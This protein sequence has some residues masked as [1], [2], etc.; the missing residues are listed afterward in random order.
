VK[1]PY[2]IP[3]FNGKPG[4]DPKNHI[5]T[6]H[7]WF[8]SNS[9]MDESIRFRLFQRTLIDISTKWYV[10]LPQHSFKNFNTLVMAFL[11]HF[12]LPNQYETGTNLL[13]SLRQST[14]TH[15]YDHLHECRRRRRLIKAPIP[16]EILIDWFTKSL[17]PPIGQDVVMGGAFTEEQMIYCA[18]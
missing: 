3:K 10:K 4:E 6:Y 17:S 5:M 15:I 11:T 14:S 8:S 9:L 16:D 1:L 18:Q 13:T 12:Q 2:D 7:L